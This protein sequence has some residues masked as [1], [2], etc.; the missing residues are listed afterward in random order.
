MKVV[1]TWN[2]VPVAGSVRSESLWS[3]PRG[4]VTTNWFSEAN[5]TERQSSLPK[6][7]K[8]S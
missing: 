3:A 8:P 2:H 4:V 7:A 5:R 1:A 6:I